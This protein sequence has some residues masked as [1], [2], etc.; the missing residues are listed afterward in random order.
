MPKCQ[1]I[2]TKLKVRRIAS[3]LQNCL[4]MK[5]DKAQVVLVSTWER[6]SIGSYEQE[7]HPTWSHQLHRQK[8][9]F[10]T[11]LPVRSSTDSCWRISR[12]IQW[13]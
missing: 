4:L 8:S 13:C 10:Y 6:A 12:S 1:S 11:E 7:K 2:L 9:E 3:E 5:V